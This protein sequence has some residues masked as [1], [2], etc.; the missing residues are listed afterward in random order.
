MKINVPLQAG[1][2]PDRYTKHADAANKVG[3]YPVV[4]FPIEFQEVP[5]E[6]AS[7]AV[8]LLDPDS[9]PVCGF[10][11]IHWVVANLDPQLTELPADASQSGAVAMTYGNNSLAGGLLHV[12]D[13]QLNRH[14]LGPTPPDQPHHYRL[15]VYAL[16]QKLALPDGFWLNQLE[17]KLPG[18]VLATATAILPV[19]N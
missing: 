12:T 2:L 13:Q 15:T 7:L 4:S 11:Y 3:T 9:I 19:K 1:F 14:Y 10:E 5:S 18:H 16:D 6:A 17:S 8:T